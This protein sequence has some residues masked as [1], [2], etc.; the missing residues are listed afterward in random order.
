VTSAVSGECIASF[1]ASYPGLTIAQ[2]LGPQYQNPFQIPVLV[3]IMNKLIMGTGGTPA[4]PVLLA[5]GNADGTGDGIMV[6][7]DVEALAHEYCQ[8]GVPV[9]FD[10]YAGLQHTPAAVPFEADAFT[11]LVG[12]FAG[13][14]APDGCAS[15]GTGNSLAPLPAPSS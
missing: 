5:V 8:R 13:L 11:F 15:I 4:S 2:L 14:P 3:T 1:A 7:G 9:T 12:R 6:A 10:E